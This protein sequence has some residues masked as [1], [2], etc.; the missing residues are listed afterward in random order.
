MNAKWTAAAA[1]AALLLAGCGERQTAAN[2]TDT[3]VP[4]AAS[5]TVT[6]ERLGVIGAEIEKSPAD[7]DRILAKNGLDRESFE[8]GIRMVSANPA[9]ARKY[10]D[11]YQKSRT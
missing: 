5:T 1:V 2:D 10:R 8:K 4:A 3:S 7:A 6:A 11:A 9:E